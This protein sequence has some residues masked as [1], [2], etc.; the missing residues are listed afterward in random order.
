MALPS[1]A[2]LIVF[3]PDGKQYEEL[4]RIKVSDTA[5][6]AHPVLAGNRIFIRDQESVTLLTV[7]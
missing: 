5:V 1:S 4:A 7:Q 3:K 2:E 6:Y